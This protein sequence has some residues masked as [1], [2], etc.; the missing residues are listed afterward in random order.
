MELHEVI[1]VLILTITTLIDFIQTRA[2]KNSQQY[3][4]QKKL[5]SNS[6]NMEI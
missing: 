4:M 1:I 5:L 2:K 6:I 3:F